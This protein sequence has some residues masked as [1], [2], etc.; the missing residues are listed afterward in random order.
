MKQKPAFSKPPILLSQIGVLYRTVR[1]NAGALFREQDYPLDIDQMPVLLS[2]YYS[3]GVSQQAMGIALQRDKASINRT[4]AFLVKTGY[5]TV[6]P[7]QEN[8]RKTVVRA[9]PEG[10]KIA[11]KADQI[12][13]EYSLALSA[14]LSPEEQQQLHILLNKLI[15]A[16]KSTPIKFTI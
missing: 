15:E 10:I 8:K 7:D 16:E 3:G 13:S 4:V 14:A 12:I 9:T 5:A 6:E 2:A 11:R 1:R